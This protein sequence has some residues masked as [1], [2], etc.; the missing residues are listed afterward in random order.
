MKVRRKNKGSKPSFRTPLNFSGV[1]SSEARKAT[2]S[3]KKNSP[4]MRFATWNVRTMRTGLNDNLLELTDNRKTAVIEREL[5]RLNIDIAALQE[6]RLAG[7]GTLREKEYTFFWRGKSA[8]E[9]REHGVGFAVRN[10]LLNM[11]ETPNEGSERLLSL[12]LHT[13]DGPV[14]IF[15][16]YAPTLTSDDLAKDMFYEKLQGSIKEIPVSE[17]I[18]LLGDFNAR[19]GKDHLSWPDCIGIHGV[20]NM[21]DNGQRLLETCAQHQLCVTNTLY[22]TKPRQRVSWMHPRSKSW[23]Q[24]DL[25]IT[26]RNN[27][28]SFMVTRTYHSADCDTDHSLVLCKI[29]LQPKKLH[30]AKPGG[31]VKIDVTKTQIES[32]AN[33]FTSIIGTEFQRS[34]PDLQANAE[35]QWNQIRDTVHSQALKT[36]GKKERKNQDW[37]AAC[38]S[39]ITPVLEEK[40]MAM[41]KHK[42]NPS[43]RTLEA[44]RLTRNNAQRTAR[45][46]ANIYWQELSNKIQI[47]S[48]TGNIRGVY[49]GIKQATGPCKT[50][51][52]PLR[53]KD[54][55]IITEKAKQ[56]DRWTE[57]YGELLT[58]ETFVAES[59]MDSI[60]ILPC[61]PELDELPSME[62]VS[63]AIDKLPVGKA[64]GL[65]GIPGEVIKCG[66][67]VLLPTLHALLCKCWDE[68]LFPQDMRDC[69]IV[70]L[71]KNK[72]DKSDCNNYRGISLLSIVGKLFARVILKRLQTLA[73]RV[74]PESQCGFRAGRSTGDMIFSIRQLQEKCREK[75][76]PLFIA[77]IDLTKAFDLVNRPALFKALSKIGCPPKLLSLIKSFHTDMKGVVQF[78]G[79]TSDVFNITSGVKQGCVLAP[80]LFGTFFSLILRCAFNTATE[81]VYFHTRSDGGLF[82][83]S[84]LRARTKRSPRTARDMLFADDAAFVAN[85]EADLQNLM[86][87][88]SKAAEEFG[89]KI[90]IKKTNILAQGTEI[91]PDIKVNSESL[92]VVGEFTYLGSTIAANLSLDSELNRRIG[93]ASSTFAKLSHKVWENSKLSI[94]TKIDVYKACVL[95]TLLYASETWTLYAKQEQKINVFHMRKLRSILNIKCFKQR[96]SSESRNTESTLTDYTTATPM[97]RTCPPYV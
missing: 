37:F 24:L 34:P 88:F 31:K 75:R 56:L 41:L 86:D 50:T 22:S 97:V 7:S 12:R 87:R 25:I 81:G 8:E 48:D 38:I 3:K 32:S 30:W 13:K 84:R 42:Q 5:L 29:K 17:Q 65:D 21:N 74:Y 2:H 61:M 59:A 33:A 53:T 63:S 54:G 28:K 39:K 62:E 66:K 52:A 94:K 20:G 73:E 44:V 85:T 68:G 89:M 40:R 78:D 45:G 79:S 43:R 57:Y 4:Q 58:R 16:A 55:V 80:T 23:H 36:F 47:A 64:P 82:N 10:S 76:Q 18:I 35:V 77:F 9:V 14:N 49:E 67:D 11:I 1:H 27:I 15:S 46:C 72:G 70:T 69:K 95:S 90:S 93:R 19:I 6:T 83:I 71:Y 92:E 91:I 96:G 26:R 60:E 51:C